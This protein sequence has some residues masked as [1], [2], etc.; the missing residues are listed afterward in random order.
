MAERFSRESPQQRIYTAFA[1][2]LAQEDAAIDLVEAALLIAKLVYPEVDIACYQSQL[3]AL[4]RRVR[5]ILGLS[6]TLPLNAMPTS[7]ERKPHEF[8]QA[9]NQVIFA[10]EGFCGNSGDYN[11]PDN[12]YL[13]KV[14][15]NR[16]GIPL[17]LSLVYIEVAR[18]A[19][20]S[21]EGIGLPYHFI[22]R[23]Q[24]GEE[25]YYIDAFHQ[26]RLLSEQECIELVRR[27][28]H[29]PLKLHHHWF[30]P[31]L[32]KQM[33][34]RMLNN[35]KRIYLERD[36]YEPAL[37]IYELMVLLH[38]QS[39]IH[40]RERG[41]LHLQL[42][43]YGRALHDLMAYRELA[44]EAKDRYEVLNYIKMIRQAIAMMN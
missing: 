31:V 34:G 9:L 16:A 15:D 36:A 18:R 37:A 2:L 33:L 43:H 41:L 13:N 10:E 40:R 30:E 44:P 26:G 14:L 32:R 4:A 29:R 39:A 11:N 27:I 7:P 1:S 3:D 19:G 35:L 5:G 12:S 22:S 6:P 20:L 28:A 8:L 25:T 42:K 21:I 24:Y 17:T 23:C 38:P